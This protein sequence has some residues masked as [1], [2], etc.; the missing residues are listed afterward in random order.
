MAEF[1]QEMT[2]VIPQ[3][4]RY[5]RALVNSPDTA[6]DLVQD[7]LEQAL[8]K[9]HLWNESQGMRPWLFTILHNIYAS[10]ARRYQRAPAMESYSSM[11]E[12]SSPADNIDLLLP[13]LQRAMDML[14]DEYR[15]VL[16]LV[17]LEQMSYKETSAVLDIPVGTV[18]SRLARARK[19]LR[20]FI[21]DPTIPNVPSIRRIK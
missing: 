15:Q 18:M 13:D 19:K 17:G 3:L 4:R 2:H 12:I 9:K 7:T 5:A 10:A 16:L 21:T 14:S 1:R 11:P 8:A 20:A 6:D